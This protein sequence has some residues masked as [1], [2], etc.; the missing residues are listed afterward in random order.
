MAIFAIKLAKLA[1]KWQKHWL[2]TSLI[3]AKCLIVSHSPRPYWPCIARY[4]ETISAI[5]PYCACGFSCLNMTNSVRYPL[6]LFLAFPPW[7]AFEVE[8]QYSPPPKGYLGDTCAIP[9]ENLAK[10]LEKSK[11]PPIDSS[12]SQRGSVMALSAPSHGTKAL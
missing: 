3:I 1:Q 8:V 6:P 7:R 5:P 12:G 10:C 9:H 4:R 11:D 2:Q